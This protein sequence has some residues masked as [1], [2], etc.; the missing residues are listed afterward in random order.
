ML[1]R[2]T[3]YGHATTLLEDGAR[4]L[5]DPVLTGSLAHL[6]RRAGMSPGGL[7]SPVDAVLISHLHADHLHLPSLALLPEGTPVLLPR[8]AA[9]LLRGL[10]VQP[11]EVSAGDV[12]P[13]GAAEVR[14]VPA[15]HDAT[16]WPGGR[17]RGDAVGY[18]LCGRGATYFAGDT[19]P[20]PSMAQ[21]HPSLDVALLPV[22]GWGPWLRGSHLTPR[23]AAGCLPLLGAGVCVPIHY[24][25]FWPRGLSRVRSHVFHEPG[26]E[27]G[28]HARVLAPQVDVRVLPP[29]SSTTIRVITGG[30]T[31]SSAADEAPAAT[32]DQTPE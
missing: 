12:V 11:V 10:D 2:V 28:R 23:T 16:R 4:V 19:L 1:I 27:F 9:R 26:R 14:V 29:G 20:F 30:A 15:V 32:R 22:G 31:E 5:T 13:V 21:L 8:G 25:T 6:R 17:V 24:G 3:W 18:V 7:V